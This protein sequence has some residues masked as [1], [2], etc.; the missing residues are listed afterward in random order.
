MEM[1][2]VGEACRGR[3]ASLNK[4]TFIK[5][6]CRY[7]LSI[8]LTSPEM[9]ALELAN[10]WIGKDRPKS[11]HDISPKVGKYPLIKTITKVIPNKP[12][13]QTYSL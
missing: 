10:V 2:A 4:T 12:W 11:N 7:P 6:M 5:F 9:I 13:N 8:S 1:K 3:T